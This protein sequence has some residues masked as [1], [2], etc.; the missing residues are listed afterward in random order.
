MHY[1]NTIG[2][3][4][5]KGN[6][7]GSLRSIGVLRLAGNLAEDLVAGGKEYV[8]GAILLVFLVLLYPREEFAMLVAT[9]LNSSSSDLMKSEVELYMSSVLILTGLLCWFPGSCWIW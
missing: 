3:C 9:L 2:C 7:S 6:D 5:D 4:K 1:N 8:S